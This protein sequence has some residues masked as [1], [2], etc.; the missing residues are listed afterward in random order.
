SSSSAWMSLDV[1]EGESVRVPVGDDLESVVSESGVSADTWRKY[2]RVEV[3]VRGRGLSSGVS[4]ARWNGSAVSLSSDAKSLRLGELD[5]D[6]GG[7]G[8]G[9]DTGGV[10]RNVLE[11]VPAASFVGRVRASLAYV[12]V[13]K[14]S[15]R[16]AEV[17][18]G[19]W[20]EVQWHRREQSVR[21][22]PVVV[23]SVVYSNES[24]AVSSSELFSLA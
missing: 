22:G 21:V 13:D 15:M 2:W 17:V 3:E 1:V 4:G 23:R 7:V 9:S 16:R 10:P 12:F 8:V 5:V 20:L 24:L 18:R 19:L 14:S 11:L 6:V